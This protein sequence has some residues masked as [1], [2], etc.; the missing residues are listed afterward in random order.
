MASDDEP[1]FPEPIP[2][3]V[4]AIGVIL[5]TETDWMADANFFDKTDFPHLKFRKLAVSQIA[6]DV[7]DAPLIAHACLNIAAKMRGISADTYAVRGFRQE[8]R[9]IISKLEGRV[10]S[11][12]EF[13]TRSIT[14]FFFLN[15]FYPMFEKIGGFKRRSINEIIIQAQ[16][17]NYFV[18]FKPS[19]IAFSSLLAATSLLYPSKLP[20]IAR[21]SGMRFC[22]KK[23]VDLC[24]EKN[25]Q[26]KSATESEN[27]SSLSAT[28]TISQGQSEEAAPKTETESDQ[29]RPGKDVVETSEEVKED[30]TESENQRQAKGRAAV[31]AEKLKEKVVVDPFAEREAPKRL[32]NFLLQW[33]IG[34]PILE[35]CL[36]DEPSGSTSQPVA[37]QPVAEQPAAEQPVAEQPV[38]EQPVA[39][40]R[41]GGED[42]PQNSGCACK[43]HVALV[44]FIRLRSRKWLWALYCSIYSGSSLR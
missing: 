35:R 29:Q 38:A 27:D 6:R 41:V 8:Y 16:G 9:E 23:L 34:N 7:D 21:P 33:K 11:G 4:Q 17:E 22:D 43:C 1:E 42:V 28:V 32:M 30:E 20:R 31:D 24:N 25:I 39:M 40:R 37:M 26:I 19:E 12:L 15:Y 10:L 3:E 18:R 14:P 5:L 44:H 36:I 13:K 2:K